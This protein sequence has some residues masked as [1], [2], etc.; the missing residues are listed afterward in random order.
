MSLRKY[1]VRSLAKITPPIWSSVYQMTVRF[2]SFKGAT[3]ELLAYTFMFNWVKNLRL[4][5]SMNCFVRSFYKTNEWKI[6]FELKKH[7]LNLLCR[8]V[9]SSSY[10]SCWVITC[11]KVAPVARLPTTVRLWNLDIRFWMVL[12]SSVCKWSGSWMGSGQAIWNQDKWPLFV[13][14]PF[15]IWTKTSRFWLVRSSYVQD[16]SYNQAL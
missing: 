15:N 2:W 6:I 5:P 3:N 10:L 16:H 11:S 13:I 9:E 8:F 12:K 1:L 14:K 4:T 7:F